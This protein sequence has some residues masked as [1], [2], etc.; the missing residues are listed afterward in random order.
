MT[1]I[2]VIIVFNMDTFP[3]TDPIYKKEEDMEKIEVGGMTEVG[4]LQMD[5]AT[6]TSTFGTVKAIRRAQ[7]T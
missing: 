7:S 3:K 6:S 4:M 2:N 1:L 5:G